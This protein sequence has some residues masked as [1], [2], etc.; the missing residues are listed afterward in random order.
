MGGAWI[1]LVPR[2]RRV[3]TRLQIDIS[4]KL[5]TYSMIIAVPFK[6]PYCMN[7]ENTLQDLDWA[8]LLH[9][10]TFIWPY[11][12]SC[13]I[14]SRVTSMPASVCCLFTLALCYLDKCTKAAIL[15]FCFVAHAVEQLGNNL[16]LFCY[17][18]FRMFIMKLRNF[19]CFNCYLRS[20]I[21]LIWEIF[22]Y[23]A[24]FLII[25]LICTIL[26]LCSLQQ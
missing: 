16:P 8:T 26:L 11:S 15:R 12:H 22:C 14:D 17:H 3:G 19:W 9:F 6:A 24:T 1:S 10:S 25:F 7:I 21:F 13:T 18:S 2:P 20:R 4:H 23:S 5:A